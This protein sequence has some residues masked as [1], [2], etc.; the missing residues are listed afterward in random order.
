MT[1]TNA[2]IIFW[3]VLTVALI[4]GLL[5]M[6]NLTHTNSVDDLESW[7]RNYTRLQNRY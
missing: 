7:N 2:D 4:V 3:G 6:C 5:V 1:P